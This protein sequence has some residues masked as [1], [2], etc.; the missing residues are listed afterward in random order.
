LRLL[1]FLLCCGVAAGETVTVTILATTDLHGNLEPWDYYA[2]KPAERGLAKIATL[3]RQQRAGAPN[4]LLIDCGDTIQGTP[5]EYVHQHFIQTGQLPLDLKFAGAPLIAD[6]MM[7]AMNAIGYDAMVVGNHE[8]NF[9]EKNLL[10]ARGE[11]RFPFLSANT[12]KESGAEVPAFD[13]WVVK[14]VG[15]VRVAVIGVTTPHIPEWEPEGHYRG[16]RFEDGFTAVRGAIARLQATEHP[17]VILVAAHAGLTGGGTENM[18]RTIAE[19]APGVDAVIFGHTHGSLPGRR[20]GEVLVMQPKNWGIS[21]GR[22]DLTLERAAGAKWHVVAKESRLIPVTTVVRPD[23]E[24]ETLAQPYH[25]LA[26]QYLSTRVT[27]APVDLSTRFSRV[28]DSALIDAI[29]QVQLAAT[30]ADVSFA[31]SFTPAVRVT[32]GAVTVRELAA[33]YPY[34]NMLYVVDGDGRMVREALETAARCFLTCTGDCLHQ[35][36]INPRIIGYNFDMAEGV[37]YEIDIR[38]PEGRRIRNLTWRG[39]PL[40]DDQPLRI[41]VNDHRAGGGS[42]FDMFRGARVEWQ[43]S[44]DIREMLIHYYAEHGPL[45]AKPDANWRILPAS[46]R[47]ALER[48]AEQLAA[49]P[50]INK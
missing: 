42:G 15:G 16:Y 30:H 36:L 14:L 9:G 11:A 22:M 13:P 40:A 35:T 18:V 28:E 4:S 8:W 7:L 1:I 25:A 19:E 38:Q 41:A 21:L 2:A 50:P 20:F 31:S 26:E 39:R 33:L 3:V 43:S 47:G 34:E 27:D 24:I 37:S 5:L 17:D 48:E 23:R 10:A 12:R 46:A 45:P 29:Q 32:K 49:A 6:P 44:I